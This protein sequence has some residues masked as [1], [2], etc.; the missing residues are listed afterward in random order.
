MCVR[1]RKTEI[2]TAC[3][4]KIEHAHTHAHTHARTYPPTHIHTHTHIDTHTYIY[5]HTHIHTYTHTSAAVGKGNESIMNAS[6]VRE[7]LSHTGHTTVDF[8]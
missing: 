7:T 5:T 1:E 6:N 2:K 4:E 3:V 8:N